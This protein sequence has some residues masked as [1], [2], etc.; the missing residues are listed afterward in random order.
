MSTPDID[1][2][3]AQLWRITIPVIVSAG[4]VGALTDRLI[5]TLCP[6]TAHEGGCP[7]PWAL[8]VTDGNSLSKAEQRRLRAEIA[9]TNG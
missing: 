4:E 8:R 7:T 6:D 1:D 5:A 3:P 9:D 2:G